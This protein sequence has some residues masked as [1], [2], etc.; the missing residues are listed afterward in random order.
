MSVANVKSKTVK[1]A[2]VKK[3]TKAELAALQAA[4]DV[5]QTE[6]VPLSDL[7][8]SPFNVRTIPY[9]VDSVRSLAETIASV[10]LLQNLIVHD[11][12]R[13][14]SGVAAGGLCG[15]LECDFNMLAEEAEKQLDV[16]NTQ[17][18]DWAKGFGDGREFAG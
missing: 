5:A 1:K 3:P 18:G 8:K 17:I 11:M 6:V 15:G 13:G 4:I 16:L 2:S 12:D 7:V 9:S 14:Q 10:G